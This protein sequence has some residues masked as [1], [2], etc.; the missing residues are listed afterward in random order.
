MNPTLS[1]LLPLL[2]GQPALGPGC[3]PGCAPGMPMNGMPMN[4]MPMM[5]MMR[6]QACPPVGPPAPVLAMKALLPDG[7]TIN[8]L[9]GLGNSKAYSSGSTFG[10][11]PGYS[12][13]LQIQIPG[14]ELALYPVLEIRGSI[15]P[16]TGM[17]F[18]EIA[19]PLLITK[20]DIAKVQ[21]GG[22]VVK[23]IYLEDPTKAIPTA[24][25]PDEPIELTSDH[26]EAALDEAMANGRIVALLRIGD[27]IPDADDLARLT[28][29]GAILLP[30]E[31]K[32][33]PPSAPAMLPCFPVPLYDPLLGPKISKEECFVNGGDGGDRLGVGP[34]GR[35]GGLDPT[36]VVA[37]YSLNGMK[38]TATSN[39]VCI[40]SPRFIVRKAEKAPI[41]LIVHTGP[42]IARQTTGRNVFLQRTIVENLIAR[43]KTLTLVG[44]DRPSAAVA[45][46]GLA[47]F[48]SLSKPQGF[49]TITGVLIT[50]TVVEPDEITNFPNELT[51]TK[52]VDPPGPVEQGSIITITI[53]Y[54]N[55][56]PKTVTDLVISD[57]LSGRLEYIPGS[58]AADR[59]SNVTTSANDAGSA[60]VRF[61]LPG[62]I[63]PGTT[64]IVQ[65]KAKVR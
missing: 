34:Y 25:K 65:F 51:L 48:G 33:G 9:P 35:V 14:K 3:G 1:L 4:G 39:V 61:D 40:C 47:S 31:Q 20:A 50:A 59:P 60:I 12:Y 37:E 11:R 55:Y 64:G 57:S 2:M 56:T 23:V 43:D 7:V 8:P 62:N 49:A 26:S 41:G 5:P 42:G 10:F 13:P 46:I 58:A 29:Q 19:A 21:A 52:T 53:R 45:I 32:L 30:G 24:A 54:S 22:Y 36:D 16:R 15:V 17:K 27:R 18:M 6:Q 63:P 28:V 44:K 38:K